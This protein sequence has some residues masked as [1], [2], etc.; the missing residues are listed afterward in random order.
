MINALER[1]GV[2]FVS[3][4]MLP[5]FKVIQSMGDQ[6]T[7]VMYLVGVLS[8]ILFI[9][10]V[11]GIY[12]LFVEKG[13]TDIKRLFRTCFAMPG[14]LIVATSGTGPVG[15]A[16]AMEL[17]REC[18]VEN[19]VVQGISD[20]IDSLRN[21]KKPRYLKLSENMRPESD[22]IVVDAMTLTAK[23]YWVVKHSHDEPKGLYFDIREC[24]LGGS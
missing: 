20:A 11:M 1:F 3:A 22:H 17:H 8:P 21:T 13:E 5:T 15:T 19:Q 10:L 2:G 18:R 16:T 6:P 23:V 24:R 12:A 7:T 9:S 14:A 4:L